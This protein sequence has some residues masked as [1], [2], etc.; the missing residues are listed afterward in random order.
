MCS[1]AYL[2]FDFLGSI[3]SV[4]ICVLRSS[5]CRCRWRTSTYTKQQT[6]KTRQAASSKDMKTR[7]LARQSE[8]STV[9]GKQHLG[10]WWSLYA[11]FEL[12]ET[13]L[14]RW[15]FALI[16]KESASKKGKGYTSPRRAPAAQS[17]I[18]LSIH[19]SLPRELLSDSHHSRKGMLKSNG[20]S[21]DKDPQP[22]ERLCNGG[23]AFS[24]WRC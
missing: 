2:F 4:S 8:S 23:R 13:F 12:L 15:L 14:L 17:R 6:Y 5:Q 11:C 10:K 7:S 20:T 22:L 18:S 9:Q 19:R 3:L 16:I 21:S 1:N 24:F